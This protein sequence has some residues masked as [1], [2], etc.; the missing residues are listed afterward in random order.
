[1]LAALGGDPA[2]A[3]DGPLPDSLAPL[4]ALV[5]ALPP[6]QTEA[7]LIDLLARLVEP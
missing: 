7:L 5:E 6:E 2:A 4:L 1:A 3:L